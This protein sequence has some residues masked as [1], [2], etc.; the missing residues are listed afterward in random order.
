MSKF[1][2]RCDCFDVLMGIR[3]ITDFSKVKVY[4]GQEL[5][6]LRIDSYKD[7]VPYFPYLVVTQTGDGKGNMIVRLSIKSCVD[8]EEA[9][10]LLIELNHIK[11]YYRKCKREKTEYIEEEALR[12]ISWMDGSEYL[13]ELVKRVKEYGEK[14]TIDEIHIPSYERDRQNLYE[15]M[16][17]VGWTED[18]AY[19]WCFGWGRWLKRKKVNEYGKET[20]QQRLPV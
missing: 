2:G 20:V 1:S 18:Q 16:L 10:L 14:A 17:R 12:R 5:V 9:E 6:P 8:T 13:K 7:L 4:I 11:K 3:E 15:E 19:R